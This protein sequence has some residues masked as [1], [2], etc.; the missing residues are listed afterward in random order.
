MACAASTD[1]GIVYVV[2]RTESIGHSLPW[3]GKEP[4]KGENWD[5]CTRW[6]GKE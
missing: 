3:V 6:S 5:E 1:K 2:G 4:N